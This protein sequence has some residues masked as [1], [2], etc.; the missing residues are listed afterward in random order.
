MRSVRLGHT[1]NAEMVRKFIFSRP[2]YFFGR[3]QYTPFTDLLPSMETP[4][5]PTVAQLL[6]ILIL[7]DGLVSTDVPPGLWTALKDCFAAGLIHSREIDDGAAVYYLVSELHR[8]Y[9]QRLLVPS[10][11]QRALPHP[12]PISLAVDVI[13]QFRQTHLVNPPR[14]TWACKT[15]SPSNAYQKEFYRSLYTLAGGRMAASPELMTKTGHGGGT[16][17]FLLPDKRWGYE[18][19]RDRNRL[20]ELVAGFSPAG[21]DG[22][23]FEDGIVSDYVILD[24]TTT[25]PS[26][27]HPGKNLGESAS[28]T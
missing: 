21:D 12:N 18:L 13:R 8:W 16:V 28:S 11:P 1:I 22:Y 25:K 20:P 26:E 5:E 15:P 3:L 10:T 27:A 17:D 23:L 24:F 2:S 14:N 9:C 7:N 19:V 6:E 4:P